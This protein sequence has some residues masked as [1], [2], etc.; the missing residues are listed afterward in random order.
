MKFET[1]LL[2]PLVCALVYVVGALA[3]KRAA[4]MGVGV[5]RTTFLSNWTIAVIFVPVWFWQQGD[6]FRLRITATAADA[7]L[8]VTGQVLTFF[9]L[10]RGD[11]SVVTRCWVKRSFWSRYSASLLRLGPGH[12]KWWIGAICSTVAILLLHLGGEKKQRFP[13]GPVALA[14]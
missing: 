11:W 7:A 14:F 1:T 13:I 6:Y 8:F 12:L 10:S 3:V 5:W 9:A 4:E 2:I